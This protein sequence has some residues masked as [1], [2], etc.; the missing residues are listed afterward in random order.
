[1]EIKYEA[2][3]WLDFFPSTN[4]YLK[5][6]LGDFLY[7]KFWNDVMDLKLIDSV[8]AALF[9][10]PMIL[11]T[12]KQKN[13]FLVKEKLTNEQ[14]SFLEEIAHWESIQGNIQ[15]LD[16]TGLKKVERLIINPNYRQMEVRSPLMKEYLNIDAGVWGF[17]STTR[18]LQL[19]NLE[20]F[21]SCY[22]DKFSIK[23]A[24]SSSC[25]NERRSEIYEVHDQLMQVPKIQE[26][27]NL[28]KD[29]TKNYYRKR[30]IQDELEILERLMED[31]VF[32]ET[33]IEKP[34]LIQALSQLKNKDIIIYP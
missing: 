28:N 24:V 20:S 27:N 7:H 30:M 10:W 18:D 22:S 32:L 11:R 13:S 6:I 1:M 26:I 25:E 31:V 3:G 17:W 2:R 8:G 12:Q 19:K 15:L 29:Y 34:E 4:F 5:K 21:A 14:I 33:E 9:Y 23:P 16:E